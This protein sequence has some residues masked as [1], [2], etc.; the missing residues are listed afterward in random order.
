MKTYV[1]RYRP[2]D[3]QADE[4]QRLAEAVFAELRENATAG[5]RYGA[6]RL[7]DGTF[8]HV[9]EVD[10]PN[11]LSA[12]PSFRTFLADVVERCDPGGKPDLQDA[13]VLGNYRLLAT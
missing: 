7:D 1:V 13:T 2:R 8:I 10:E 3:D 9:A 5:V 4:N 12:L 6:F 11:P